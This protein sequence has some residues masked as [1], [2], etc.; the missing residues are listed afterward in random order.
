MS[1]PLIFRTAADPLLNPSGALEEIR[2]ALDLVWGGGDRA[3]DVDD[4]VI[5][6]W[7]ERNETENN[8]LFP[9]GDAREYWQDGWLEKQDHEVQ[10]IFV[11]YYSHIG[12]NALHSGYE[13]NI[14]EIDSVEVRYEA[15]EALEWWIDIWKNSF[16][17][18]SDHP[19]GYFWIKGQGKLNRSDLAE[20]LTK[21]LSRYDWFSTD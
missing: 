13:Y 8:D 7:L 5:D 19:S 6:S 4:A 1:E 11:F 21:I 16:R 2:T 14:D 9:D 12:W 17:R 10:V 20:E 3:C 18:D 15:E